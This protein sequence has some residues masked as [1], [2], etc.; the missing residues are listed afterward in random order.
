MVSQSQVHDI[1][2]VN[3][4]FRLDHT[5]VGDRH[6]R[7]LRIA[8]DAGN[9]ALALLHQQ[10]RDHAGQRRIERGLLQL[11]VGTGQDGGRG[12]CAAQGSRIGILHLLDIV[13]GHLNLRFHLG[14][15]GLGHV[16]LGLGYPG[17]VLSHLVFF[18]R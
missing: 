4:Q 17:V 14:Q 1:G 2:L 18:T 9:G 3:F 8:H 5:Q 10:L 13:S 12:F 15:P 7:R 11:I 6:E 16:E